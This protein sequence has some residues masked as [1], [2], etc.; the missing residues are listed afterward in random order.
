MV[1]VLRTAVI[2]FLRMG[3]MESLADIQENQ[4]TYR[5]ASTM[6]SATVSEAVGYEFE[7][8]AGHIF[9]A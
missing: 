7:S 8:H 3:I 6:D 5:P 2:Y 9:N 4:L 1:P